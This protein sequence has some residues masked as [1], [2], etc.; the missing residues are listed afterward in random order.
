MLNKWTIGIAAACLGGLMTFGARGQ[1]DEAAAAENPLLLDGIAAEVGEK[2]ITVAEAMRAAH[3]LAAAMRLTGE[4]RAARLPDLYG[5]AV[6]ELVARALILRH[7]RETGQQLQP[8]IVDRRV[9][10]IIADR[11]GGDRAALIAGLSSNGMSFVEWRDRIEEEIILSAMRH[12]FVERHVIV[13]PA[14]VRAYYATNRNEFVLE[15]PVRVGMILLREGI[16]EDR[17]ALLER[18]GKLEQQ[19]RD[20]VDF[21][22][23]A[24]RFSIEQHA[25]QGGDW[26]YVD[27]ENFRF[28]LVEA[29]EKMKPG[30]ISAPIATDSGVY[31]LRKIDERQEPVLPLEEAWDRVEARLR[32]DKSLERYRAWIEHLKTEAYVKILPMPR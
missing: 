24:Q 11:F 31:I 13:S 12:Q 4:E 1:A 16:D 2:R 14:E 28:E 5:E 3:E 6:E 32:R 25:D 29:L 10:E 30:D 22:Q 19:L 26:G 23:M 7:Y 17:E 8:W 15:G 27:P 9:E 21:A 18:A 20:G